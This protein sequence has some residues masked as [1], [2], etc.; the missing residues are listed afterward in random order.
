MAG[1]TA[2]L[3]LLVDRGHKIDLSSNWC[4]RCYVPFAILVQFRSHLLCSPLNL[5]PGCSPCSPPRL[6]V[7]PDFERR[8][9]P[10]KRERN[11]S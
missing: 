8:G 1:S 9:I 5:A 11:E 7:P 4:E 10:I 6:S 3:K 2:K